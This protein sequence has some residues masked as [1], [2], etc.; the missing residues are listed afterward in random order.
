V[1]SFLKTKGDFMCSAVTFVV[2][3]WKGARWERVFTG[4]GVAWIKKMGNFLVGS[5]MGMG[6]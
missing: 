1:A 3:R 5:L 4:F 6:Y 2:E